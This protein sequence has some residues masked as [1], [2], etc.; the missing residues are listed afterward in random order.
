VTGLWDVAARRHLDAPPPS[1]ALRT[2]DVNMPTQPRCVPSYYSVFAHNTTPSRTRQEAEATAKE[3]RQLLQQ[4]VV[5][6]PRQLKKKP[7][8]VVVPDYQGPF[9]HVRAISPP[10]GSAPMAF[11]ERPPPPFP[12]QPLRRQ[13]S[14]SRGP[15]NFSRPQRPAALRGDS[16]RDSPVD[17]SL[18]K[19]RRRSNSVPTIPT[20]RRIVNEAHSPAW[21]RMA[22]PSL[23]SPASEES[24]QTSASGYSSPTSLSS[25]DSFDTSSMYHGERKRQPIPSSPFPAS[26]AH[27]QTAHVL[28]RVPSR[29]VRTPT[30]S[31]RADRTIRFD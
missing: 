14:L 10:L 6:K 30:S 1:P 31:K 12:Q 26:P 18:L 17:L 27:V 4:S 23:R 24:L 16:S 15:Q 21:S 7:K 20:Q 11:L 2:R 19:L 3:A 22:A 28:K 5:T 9:A 25:I 13:P 29:L 8:L